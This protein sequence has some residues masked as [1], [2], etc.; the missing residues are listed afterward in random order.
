MQC[1]GTGE[2]KKCSQCPLGFT[3]TPPIAPVPSSGSDEPSEKMIHG[4]CNLGP[5]LI[6]TAFCTLFFKNSRLPSMSLSKFMQCLLR[7]THLPKDLT[8]LHATLPKAKP[9]KKII[10]PRSLSASFELMVP[11]CR[12]P[13]MFSA[14]SL[15]LS[16]VWPMST[17]REDALLRSMTTPNILKLLEK[18][19][20]F[21]PSSANLSPRSLKSDSQAQAVL[22]S[23]DVL[24][25][26]EKHHKM[27]SS[28]STGPS[29]QHTKP[30][31]LCAKSQIPS[32]LRRMATRLPPWVWQKEM[33]D[34]S[35]QCEVDF[36]HQEPKGI[37][38]RHFSNRMYVQASLDDP[39][40]WCWSYEQSSKQVDLQNASQIFL[41]DQRCHSTR[42][43][44][45]HLWHGFWYPVWCQTS[46]Q[47]CN[48][49]SPS[50]VLPKASLEIFP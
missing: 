25:T 20:H 40:D 18:G 46:W 16:G 6:G 48:Q 5:I 35:L 43:R 38:Y 36:C 2:E 22:F 26:T 50:L 21:G 42:S 9:S 4:W 17:L 11:V 37:V 33:M 32:Q 3:S 13:W 28:I 10:P 27:R 39:K 1:E 34:N 47:L 44:S 14:S 30:P 8:A 12:C 41:E 45:S 23:K 49:P 31:Y 7:S 29:N 24:V 15:L 19:W